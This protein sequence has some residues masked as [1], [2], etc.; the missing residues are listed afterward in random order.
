MAE[1]ARRTDQKRSSFTQTLQTRE[2]K[3]GWLGL[4]TC[5]TLHM[6]S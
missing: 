5:N 3:I 6:I 1:L 4:I 2:V